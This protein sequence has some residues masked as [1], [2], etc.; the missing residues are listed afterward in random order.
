MRGRDLEIGVV[1]RDDR[2]LRLER[3]PAA[4]AGVQLIYRR[5]AHKK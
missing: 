3:R 4:V 1:V 2:V 5:G